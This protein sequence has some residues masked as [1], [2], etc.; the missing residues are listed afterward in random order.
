MGVIMEPDKT[1]INYNAK[2]RPPPAEPEPSSMV[3]VFNL[4]HKP[5][6]QVYGDLII[7]HAKAARDL[8]VILEAQIFDAL[9]LFEK[10]YPKEVEAWQRLN[11]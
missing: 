2:D 8:D 3:K 9:G 5:A 11:K 10:I 7:R 6:Y 1:G 4:T